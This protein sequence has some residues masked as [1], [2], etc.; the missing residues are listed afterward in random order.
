MRQLRRNIREHRDAQPRAA[1]R[2]KFKRGAVC[3]FRPQ[4]ERR[5]ERP[6]PLCGHRHTRDFNG[7]GGL[8]QSSFH[9]LRAP[10]TAVFSSFSGSPYARGADRTRRCNTACRHC[11]SRASF[12]IARPSG[13]FS[14]NF[15]PVFVRGQNGE[16]VRT[17][18]EVRGGAVHRDRRLIAPFRHAQFQRERSPVCRSLRTSPASR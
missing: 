8:G 14:V 15:S 11:C 17:H 10:S 7:G 12:R 1:V 6:I 9:S 16:T 13:D 18:N 4:F 2:H 3:R 5:I